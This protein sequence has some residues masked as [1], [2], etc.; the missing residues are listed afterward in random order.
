[1]LQYLRFN[2]LLSL[3]IAATLSPAICS[4][5]EPARESEV[6]SVPA[7]RLIPLGTKPEP[8]EEGTPSMRIVP[9]GARP[10]S[11]EGSD[12]FHTLDAAHD[13]AYQAYIVEIRAANADP[14]AGL[15]P[16]PPAIRFYAL[17]RHLADRGD[18]RA[19]LWCIAHRLEA[20]LLET[21]EQGAELKRDCETVI[22]TAADDPSAR[23]LVPSMFRAV[24]AGRLSVPDAIALAQQLHDATSDE[25]TRTHVLFGLAGIME[26]AKEPA[27][28]AGAADLYA[29]VAERPVV[30]GITERAAGK[31][32]SMHRLQVGMKAPDFTA[33]DVDG[34]PIRLADY[35][36]KVVMLDFW[37]FW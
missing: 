23:G 15:D 17:F 36:G 27:I 30:P 26:S 9:A 25:T 1:M 7:M 19:L 35:A 10:T 29:L 16:Q 34:K 31:A 6:R 20:G 3:V 22:R 21:K 8:Q 13:A 2:A 28:R 37:G 11:T 14:G 32:F 5:D 33:A 4:Q 12:E 18:A 24:M